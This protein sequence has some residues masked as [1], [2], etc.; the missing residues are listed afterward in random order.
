MSNGENAVDIYFEETPSVLL[1]QQ[2]IN[3]STPVAG[4]GHQTA[5]LLHTLA[6]AETRLHRQ[7]KRKFVPSEDTSHLPPPRT[8]HNQTHTEWT[9]RA[10]AVAVRHGYDPGAAGGALGWTRI[11]YQFYREGTVSTVSPLSMFATKAYDCTRRVVWVEH[12][13]PLANNAPSVFPSEFWF[14][15]GVVFSR[16]PATGIPSRY[17]FAGTRPKSSLVA[18]HWDVWAATVEES[19]VND[20]ALS[21]LPI[22]VERT[23]RSKWYR[24]P[25]I[26][27]D[28][29]SRVVDVMPFIHSMSGRD[30]FMH[31]MNGHIPIY[32]GGSFYRAGG[33]SYM[34]S[35]LKDI[36]ARPAQVS[37]FSR[38]HAKHTAETARISR[39]ST[40]AVNIG[41]S[42][43]HIDCSDCRLLYCSS[44]CRWQHS[45][46]GS[47]E[48]TCRLVALAR[49]G[50]ASVPGMVTAESKCKAPLLTKL[51]ACLTLAIGDFVP[52][53]LLCIIVHYATG[54]WFYAENAV[55]LN[56][57]REHSILGDWTVRRRSPTHLPH[58][59]A[60]I[61]DLLSV[62]HDNTLQYVPIA[63]ADTVWAFHPRVCRV[64]CWT[65]QSFP[66]WLDDTMHHWSLSV[67]SAT[68]GT[69]FRDPKR[70]SSLTCI[71]WHHMLGRLQNISA[72]TDE[73]PV[74]AS[75]TKAAETWHTVRKTSLDRQMAAFGDV[76]PHD[77]G[78]IGPTQKVLWSE[79]WT[80]GYTSVICRLD[81]A[82]PTATFYWFATDLL[83]WLNHELLQLA[84]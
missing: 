35:S 69:M 31:A 39:C 78:Y 54:T 47:H 30:P 15:R 58:E 50:Y 34:M 7:C 32:L 11:P 23:L 81:I 40:C 17:L 16:P 56:W 57:P 13:D 84:C 55:N 74:V 19:V 14:C 45:V 80:Q 71:E 70:E 4:E 68:D 6:R 59:S 42:S 18:Q 79:Y 27:D 37:L 41:L 65:A 60:D 28:F 77:M 38:R 83:P 5:L 61:Q 9:L 25:L 51:T 48:P 21:P 76:L 66:S 33:N 22:Q 8:Y 62:N 26:L 72:A 12:T 10:I 75:L 3:V 46:C 82:A 52:T 44:E 63:Q 43:D 29:G 73:T 67:L 49:R 1:R 36:F 64:S 53:E 2:T 24:L 20:N